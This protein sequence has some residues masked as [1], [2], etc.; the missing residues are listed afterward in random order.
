MIFFVFFPY[1]CVVHSQKITLFGAV[2]DESGAI[3]EGGDK[4]TVEGCLEQAIVHDNGMT[5]IGNDGK[6]VKTHHSSNAV[7][8]T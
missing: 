8:S 5:F 7:M 1:S 6:P 2:W 3:P 4:I